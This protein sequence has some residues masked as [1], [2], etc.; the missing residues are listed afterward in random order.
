MNFRWFSHEFERALHRPYVQIVFGTRQ[1]G[2]STLILDR[3]PPDAV[4]INLA[5]PGDLARLEARPEELV[6]RCLALPS[7][8]SAHVVFVDEAQRVPGIFDAV[9]FL[10][11]EHRNRFR[12]V[13]CGSSARKLRATGANLLPGRS[14]MHRLHPLVLPELPAPEA[15]ASPARLLPLPAVVPEHPLFP[16][17][18]LLDR[19]AFGALP[20]VVTAAPEDRADLLRSYAEIYLEEEIR[21]EAAVRDLGAFRRFLQLAAREA[22]QP[23]NLS[24]LAQELGLT[25][26]TVKSYYKILEDIFVGIPLPAFTRSARKSVLSTRRFLFFD[27]GVRHAA[28]GLRPGHDTVLANP[29]PVFEQWVGL[30]LW[31]RLQMLGEGSLSSFRTSDGAK[32]DFIIERAGRLIPVEVKF[33]E[34]P[35]MKDARHLKRFLVEHAD[36]ADEGYVICRCPHPLKLAENITALPWQAI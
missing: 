11:D 3:L 4:R 36:E 15:S 6:E 9:Q 17:W 33:T 12:F 28:A 25:H 14:M 2:K 21:G 10:H 8:E 20:G 30:E 22:G 24:A 26:P 32:I 16:S 5:R 23:V 13:L 19:L 27:L 18:D 35:S 29:G 34:H 31:R 1:C 7:R